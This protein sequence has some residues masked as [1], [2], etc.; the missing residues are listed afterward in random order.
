MF[1]VRDFSTLQ[2][3]ETGHLHDEYN[4]TK[5][6]KEFEHQM[7]SLIDMPTWP[8]VQCLTSQVFYSELMFE[9]SNAFYQNI[10]M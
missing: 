10:F 6:R 2:V 5:R 8:P 1:E 9:F 3:Y 7:T 4:S